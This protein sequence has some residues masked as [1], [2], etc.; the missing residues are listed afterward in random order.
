MCSGCASTPNQGYAFDTTFDESIQS[1]AIPIFRNE[2]TSR[3]LEVQLTEAVMKEVQHRT[4]WHLAPSDRADTTLVGVITST[5][6]SVLSDDPQTGLAQEQ[7]VRI[8]IRFEWRDNRSGDILVARDGYSAAGLFAPARNVGDRLEFG[9]RAAIDELA[10][11]L[12]SDM[13]SGW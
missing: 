3:G 9:Q 6:L 13:R 2:T 8:T 10:R 1:I 5:Q 4:P 12:I 7:A 11:D